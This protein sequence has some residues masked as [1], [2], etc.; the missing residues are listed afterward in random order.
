MA[1][2]DAAGW[3]CRITFVGGGVIDAYVTVFSKSKI[4]FFRGDLLCTEPMAHV[5]NVEPLYQ[6]H[7]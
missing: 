5:V 4:E 1:V 6:D 2:T 3:V 7:G